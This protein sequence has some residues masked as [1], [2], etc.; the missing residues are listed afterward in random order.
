MKF[1][2]VFEDLEADARL[3]NLFSETTVSDIT[4]SESL[5]RLDVY[6]DSR[7]FIKYDD[8]RKMETLLFRQFFEPENKNVVLHV[9]Y[10]GPEST[11]FKTAWDKYGIYVEDEFSNESGLLESIYRNASINVKENEL[12]IELDDNFI[13]HQIEIRLR[14][15]ISSFL[16]DYF[17][18]KVSLKFSYVK[19]EEFDEEDIQRS[20]REQMEKHIS[21]YN[22]FEDGPENTEASDKTGTES[23]GEKDKTSE[24]DSEKASK[25]QGKEKFTKTFDKSKFT[26][27]K[28]EPK[29]PDIIFGTTI[30]G[31]VISIADIIDNMGDVTVRGMVLRVYDPVTTKN[32]STIYKFSFTDFQDTIICKLFLKT[33]EDKELI[34]SKVKE[35]NFFI[36]K[37]SAESDAFEKNETTIQKIRGIKPIKDFR[38]KRM[39]NAGV[40]RI[41]LHAHT[42]MSDM[43]GVIPPAALV[44]KAFEWGHRGIAITDHGV[45][46][47]FPVANHAF[48][49]D[50]IK[51]PDELE[52]AK[53]F[54]IIYGCEGYIVD[55]EPDSITNDKGHTFYKQEDG[56]YSEEDLRK[57]P[58]YHIILLC[59]N[60]VGRI[61]LYK[62]A[63]LGHL[64]Y[65]GRFPRIPKS[66]LRENRDMMYIFRPGRTNMDKR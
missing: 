28:F 19:P 53:N 8:R 34:C 33:D 30:E 47:A 42:Q 20:Y 35:G 50:K 64:K 22:N 12:D 37:G 39:D 4:S 66:V 60:D 44:K 17:G 63:S 27:K 59:K 56:T 1:L 61:N 48:N 57:M 23:E 58:A 24:K 65:F 36:I 5:A 16:E 32:G 14:E 41:E 13:N 55:D 45:V 31:D 38:I 15:I 10:I 21:G 7:K 18:M 11:D 51:D 40:K 49:F 3:V 52:R 62:L 54:K 43:D 2:E 26:K 46:Q 9:R 29:D 6:I 25:S